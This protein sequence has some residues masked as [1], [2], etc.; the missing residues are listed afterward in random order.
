MILVGIDIGKL[1]HFTSQKR[2]LEIQ[3]SY[4]IVNTTNTKKLYSKQAKEF[5]TCTLGTYDLASAL[6]LEFDNYKNFVSELFD[7]ELK[8]VSI[9]G[10]LFDGEKV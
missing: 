6:N 8:Q 5:I 10:Y 1:S 2:L 7:I 3:K 9:N 4:D